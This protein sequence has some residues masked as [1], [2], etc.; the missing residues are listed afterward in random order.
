MQLLLWNYYI[1]KTV[2][3][4]EKMNRVNV[5]KQ[6]NFWSFNFSKEAFKNENYYKIY[7]KNIGLE[8]ITSLEVSQDEKYIIYANNSGT[9][10]ILE[11]IYNNNT[12]QYLENYEI[13]L[14]KI[15]YG[16]SGYSVNFIPINSDLSIFADCSYDNFFHLYT[17]PRWEK[18]KSIYNDNSLFNIEY[19][20]L[21]AESLPSM[22]LYCISEDKFRGYKI[23]GH[24]LN[25]EQNDK[26][27][28]RDNDK[29]VSE[30]NMISP[31][32]FTNWKFSNYLIYIF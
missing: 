7:S 6:R 26:K 20:F 10:I 16:H 24:Y 28:I 11:F 19:I 8:F 29:N 15:I 18:I 17:L 21:S 14:L 30:E 22:V 31:I 4:E 9:L 12:I 23:D 32:I 2:I 27:L 5:I 13:K 3:T 1:I 25:V